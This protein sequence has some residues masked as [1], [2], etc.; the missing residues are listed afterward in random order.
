M[1]QE[2]QNTLE[3]LE[4]GKI[5]IYPTDTIW[6]IGCDATNFEAV[7]KIYNI[8][9]RKETDSMIILMDSI[10]MLHKYIPEVPEVA[11]DIIEQSED[12]ITII[13]DNPRGLAKNLIAQDNSIAVRIPKDEFLL[14]LIHKFRKP[15]VA[16][17]ANVYGDKIPM[18]YSEINPNLLNQVDYV[19]NLEREKVATKLSS[20]IKLKSNGQVF[21]LRK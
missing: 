16:T 2:I 12:P 15:I 9:Q 13:Y 10:Q 7:E 3:T 11:Y 17:T 19:V 4:E 5:I 6:G 20:I 14:K 1:Q 8:S 21:I 18:Y